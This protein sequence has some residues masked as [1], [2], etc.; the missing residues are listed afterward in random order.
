MAYHTIF[1]LTFILFSNNQAASVVYHITASS[2]DFCDVPC[3]TLSQVI[4]DAE[5][6]HYYLRSDIT[7][8]FLPG[9]H[10]LSV[11]FSLS[12][13]YNLIMKSHSTVVQ[14]VC[15][16]HSHMTFA[17]FQHI[18]IANL[19]FIG[20]GGNYIGDTG[21]LDLQNVKFKDCHSGAALK[22][23][24]TT[25]NILNSTFVSSNTTDRGALNFRRSKVNIEESRFQN[26]TASYGGALMY[27]YDS[28]ITMRASEFDRN[29][30]G[31]VIHSSSSNLTIEMCRFQNNKAI[32]LYSNFSNVTITGSEFN[33]NI[34]KR[35]NLFFRTSKVTIKSSHFVDNTARYGA[36][37]YSHKC[38]IKIG[39]CY[40][41]NNTA[42]DGG[43]LF[44]LHSYITINAS[45]YTSN[46]ANRS[47]AILYSYHSYVKIVASKLKS[48]TAFRGGVIYSKGESI[49]KL[50]Q[51]TLWNNSAAYGGIVKSDSSNI[52]LEACI[53]GHNIASVQGGVIDSYNDT[54]KI[55]SSE[56]DS[57]AAKQA[58]SQS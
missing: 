25:A 17:R 45:E 30:I 10:Y 12:Y 44:S 54:I 39:T 56:L 11:N 49:T 22:L 43:G 9:T 51:T 2:A 8:V 20:C 52:I 16:G 4:T 38:Y 48:N 32:G 41:A 14:I 18:H 24:E 6:D 50:K 46:S 55:E 7:M 5:I 21:R 58:I 23:V 34:A 27:S 40:F 31:T 36:A 37:I 57:N 47:G 13:L 1:L 29:F 15:V 42:E 28:T 35:S 33:R 19:E 3:L 26:N 53:V